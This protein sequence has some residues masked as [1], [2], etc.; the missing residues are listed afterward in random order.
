ML[1]K[2][3]LALVLGVLFCVPPCA[4]QILSRELSNSETGAPLEKGVSAEVSGPSDSQATMATRALQMNLKQVAQERKVLFGQQ[5]TDVFGLGSSGQPDRCDIKTAVGCYPAVYGYD[6]LMLFHSK[7]VP[8]AEARLRQR[9]RAAYERGGV[10]TISWHMWNPLT[11]KNFHDPT[12]A[13]HTIL[14]GGKHHQSFLSQLEQVAA[15]F[16]SLKGPRGEAIPILF[17]PFHEHTGSW[18]WW[19]QDQCSRDEFVQLWQL[20]VRRLREHHGLHQLLYVYSPSFNASVRT[21]GD[22][23]SHMMA[24]YPGDA[25]VDVIG[26]DSYHA[27]A[28]QMEDAVERGLSIV[29]QEAERRGKIPAYT[30]GGVRN[31]LSGAWN[32]TYYTDLANSIKS[33]EMAWRIA[34]LMVWQNRDRQSA[35]WVPCQNGDPN[36]MDFQLF[37]RDPLTVFADSLPP[38]YQ[39]R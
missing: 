12:P 4:G 10:I 3:D 31:G 2:T 29:V 19:G 35:Y 37:H 16:A 24:R 15:F 34:Y 36:L 13:V 17:R 11:G 6:L 14:P 38:M 26:M 18:F 1:S 9:I 23:V 25:Y 28:K 7:Q 39:M 5:N 30:E 33:N 21:G 27:D 8:D 20:T 32:H 22:A